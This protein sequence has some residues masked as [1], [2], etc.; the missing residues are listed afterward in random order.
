M[1]D[2]I[3]SSV[4]SKHLHIILPSLWLLGLLSD[5]SKIALVTRVIEKC[6]DEEFVKQAIQGVNN[7]GN[8]RY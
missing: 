1:A 4:T 3:V 5:E 8:N 6:K 2:T 7:A